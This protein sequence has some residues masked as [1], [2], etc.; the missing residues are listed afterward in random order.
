MYV[1][2]PASSEQVSRPC[3]AVS[4]A[5]GVNAVYSG[6]KQDGDKRIWMIEGFLKSGLLFSAFLWHSTSLGLPQ[7]VVD[8]QCIHAD[9]HSL[10]RDDG[11][12]LSV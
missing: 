4:L 3:M 5:V 8:G 1:H 9:R 10:G 12:L 11:E 6:N 7:V 2:N